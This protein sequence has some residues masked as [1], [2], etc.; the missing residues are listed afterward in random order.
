MSKQRGFALIAA[1][2]LALAACGGNDEV[3]QPSA[4]PVATRAAASTESFEDIQ[5]NIFDSVANADSEKKGDLLEDRATGPFKSI[6]TSE[7]KLK[8]ILKDS[9]GLD[10]LSSSS[11]QTAISQAQDYPHSAISVMD[12]SK[13]SNLQTITVFQQSTARENWKIWGSLDILPGA[14]FPSLS[15]TEGSAQRVASDSDEGLLVSPEAALKGYAKSAQTAKNPKGMKFASD[16]LRDNLWDG[17]KTNKEA[18]GDAGTVKMSFNPAKTSPISFKT[19][20][21]GALVVGQMNFNTTIE[22]T[23]EDATVTLGSTIGALAKG[24]ANGEIEVSGSLSANYSVMVAL[25]VPAGDAKNKEIAVVGASDP[26]LTKV[27]NG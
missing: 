17:K 22:V 18:I 3:P 2:S 4:A 23:D 24:K 16:K 12:P 13:G 25:H 8:G 26:V 11:I 15:L 20:D 14:T 7:Y 10:K 27:T 6:R 1:A 21:G 9:Y 19:E 5:Q